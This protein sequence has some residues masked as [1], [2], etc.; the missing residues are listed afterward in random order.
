[1][2]TNTSYTGARK[3]IPYRPSRAAAYPNAA[4]TKDI[5][6]RLLDY[7]LTVAT[8]AGIVTILLCLLTFF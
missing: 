5:L 3:V 7:T 2:K 8:S 1:M 4:T 6:G